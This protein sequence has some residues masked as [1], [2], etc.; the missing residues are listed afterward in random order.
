MSI[1]SMLSLSPVYF[2]KSAAAPAALEGWSSVL[3]FDFPGTESCSLNLGRGFFFF[4]FSV[5]R[6]SGMVLSAFYLS[7]PDGF[8]P[9]LVLTV[10]LALVD[11]LVE[12]PDLWHWDFLVCLII[13]RYSV[14][15]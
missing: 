2:H 3:C 15:L 12:F 4:S 9:G 14:F 11:P 8:M 5:I 6:W 1:L 10:L 7:S 13:A